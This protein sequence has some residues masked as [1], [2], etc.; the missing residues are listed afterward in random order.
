MANIAEEYEML[1]ISAL[2]NYTG[3]SM[4]CDISNIIVSIA[5]DITII[6]P[7]SVGNVLDIQNYIR[8]NYNFSNYD[9]KNCIVYHDKHIII[10]LT[11][12]IV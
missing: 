2:L 11:K 6:L 9:W 4:M 10:K 3:R 7:I 5:S 8:T 1:I 12:V